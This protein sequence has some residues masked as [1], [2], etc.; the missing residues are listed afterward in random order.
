MTYSDFTQLCERRRSVRYFDEKPVTEEEVRK[1]LELARLAPSVQN[2]Q[3]WHFHVVFNDDL[4]REL[5]SCSCYGNFVEGASVFLVVTSDDRLRPAHEPLWNPRELEYSCVAAMEHVLLGATAMGLGS[6]WVSLHH[7]KAAEVLQLPR[8]E[9]VIGGILLGHFKAGE[10]DA[11]GH[12][13]RK[14]LQGMMTVH[15]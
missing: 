6:T 3:P 14:V 5:M 9:R 8:H 13:G 15:R 7:G 11:D 12:Q 10:E 1:L 2:T 4:R